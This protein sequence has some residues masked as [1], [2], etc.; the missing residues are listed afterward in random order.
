MEIKNL[1]FHIDFKSI[2]DLKKA[3]GSKNNNDLELIANSIG[4]QQVNLQEDGLQQAVG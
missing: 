4:I 3:T 2:E 1:N